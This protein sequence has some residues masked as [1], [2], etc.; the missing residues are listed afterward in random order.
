MVQI[1]G[2]YLYESG[3]NFDAFLKALDV[4]FILR[5]LAKTSKPTIEI[6]LDG[7]T[8]TIKTITTL[9]TTEI[10]FKLGEEFE[11][12]RMDGKTVKTVITLEGDSLVQ[13]QKG[14]KEVKIVREFTDTHLK[15]ICTI[16]DITSTRVYKR[17]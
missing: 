9:K 12:T 6:T 15:T 14:D 3:E 16:G 13:I 10:K 1:V 5:N 4:G 2:K 7:D 17:A 11:E 8:Y